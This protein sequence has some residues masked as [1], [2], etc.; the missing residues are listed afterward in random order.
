MIEHTYAW[1]ADGYLRE[2]RD[3][4]YCTMIMLLIGMGRVAA[5]QCSDGYTAL[6]AL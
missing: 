6:E 1:I 4:G 5:Q 3:P 2:T